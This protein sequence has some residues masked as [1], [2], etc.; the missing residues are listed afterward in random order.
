MTRLDPFTLNVL[1][2][3]EVIEVD[4][5]PLGEC[6]KVI[7]L[8]DEQFL[9]VKNLYDGSKAVGLFNRGKT[10][11]SITVDFTKISLKGKLLIRD[12]WRQKNLGHFKEL[13]TLQVPGQGVVMLKLMNK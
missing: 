13:I 3:P 5:D 10:P 12:L 2:N 9:M 6:G 4:Q 11:A 8:T 1:C 7:K